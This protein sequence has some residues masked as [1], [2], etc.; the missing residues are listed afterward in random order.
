MTKYASILM[1]ARRYR[2]CVRSDAST[3]GVSQC[4]CTHIST[5]RWYNAYNEYCGSFDKHYQT[6]R[7]FTHHKRLKTTIWKP[8]TGSYRCACDS[9]YRLN[10]NNRTCEDIDECEVHKSY[11]L[12]MGIC[13]NTPGSYKCTCP[14]G[15]KLSQDGRTCQGRSLTNRLQRNCD[16]TPAWKI[17]GCLP[18]PS[19]GRT[20]ASS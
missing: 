11:D 3:T 12:C 20:A 7:K 1:N 17:A 6:I 4:I 19:S 18:K 5:I 16:M 13:Q 8:L 14:P 2:D 10:A 9:G 15:Y